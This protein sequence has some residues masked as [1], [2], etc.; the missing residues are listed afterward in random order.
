MCSSCV[1]GRHELGYEWAKEYASEFKKSRDGG[2]KL[3]R[4]YVPDEKTAIAIAVSVW[5]PIYGDSSIEMQAP[6][7][8]YLVDDLWIVTGSLPKWTK[9][10][11]AKAIIDKNNGKVLHIMHYK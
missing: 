8:A 6:Y 7:F 9:G 3:E 4:G 1:S 10:G 2:Y 5:K 11:T